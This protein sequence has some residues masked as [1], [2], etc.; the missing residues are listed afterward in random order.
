MFIDLRPYPKHPQ[1]QFFDPSAPHALTTM[2]ALTVGPPPPIK[3]KK[4]KK[5]ETAAEVIK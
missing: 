1:Y 3:K 2:A 5:N 4:K